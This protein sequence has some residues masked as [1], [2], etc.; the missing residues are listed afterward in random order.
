MSEI[1]TTER[2]R[3]IF[4]EQIVLA[5]PNIH[6]A[7]KRTWRVL[8]DEIVQGLDLDEQ[9]RQFCEPVLAMVLELWE[10][11]WFPMNSVSEVQFRFSG[12]ELPQLARLWD[13][14]RQI[15]SNILAVFQYVP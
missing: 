1:L 9:H 14:Q 15:I 4:K 13:L 12:D 6:K 2:I 8:V 10:G 11:M 7:I 3:E 5:G